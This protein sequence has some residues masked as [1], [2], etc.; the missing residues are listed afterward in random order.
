MTLQPG[1]PA[2]DDNRKFPARV[3]R[4]VELTR[5][6]DFPLAC[7]PEVGRL[8]QLLA[9]GAGRICE[10]GT[11]YGVGAAWLTSGMSSHATLLTVEVD[12]HRAECARKLF[13]DNRSVEVATGDWTIATERGWFDLVFSDGGPKRRPGDP[14]KLLPLVRPGGL[15]VLDD[16]TP[17]LQND[18]SRQIWFESEHYRAVEV[19][20]TPES[21]VIVAARR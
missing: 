13:A 20:L 15:L 16:Y 19:T 17:G 10:L 9:A 18:V 11:A 14:E 6:N 1:L 7:T 8:L 3:W 5:K 21:A 4:A 12:P 2:Y